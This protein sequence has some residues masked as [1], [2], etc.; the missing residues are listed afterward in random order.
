MK[1]YTGE[2]LKDVVDNMTDDERYDL[3]AT[4]RTG[5]P[6]TEKMRQV[7]WYFLRG[8]VIRGFKRRAKYYIRR[9]GEWWN[10]RTFV[11]NNKPSINYYAEVGYILE[12]ADF[13]RNYNQDNSVPNPDR[14]AVKKAL[15]AYYVNFSVLETHGFL[16]DRGIS[17]HTKNRKGQYVSVVFR[18]AAHYEVLL[19]KHN[20]DIGAALNDWKQQEEL[21]YDSWL[22]GE[23]TAKT[24]RPVTPARLLNM[25]ARL[26]RHLV[27]RSLA[28]CAPFSSVISEYKQYRPIDTEISDIEDLGQ[29][30][31][32]AI[33]VLLDVSVYLDDIK[34][35][36]KFVNKKVWSWQQSP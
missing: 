27:A 30:I 7:R 19:R 26:L 23:N 4:L 21:R 17:F 29:D 35:Q 31:S 11:H 28:V 34:R 18:E 6:L 32:P 1:T 33:E 25:Y 24:V 20:F 14:V 12:L 9:N 3:L 10:S 13:I 16:Q 22:K 36:S 5:Q 2:Q 15:K 8:I